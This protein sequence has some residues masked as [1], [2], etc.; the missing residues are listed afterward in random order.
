MV[1]SIVDISIDKIKADI[2]KKMEKKGWSLDEEDDD[3]YICFIKSGKD[4]D[5][6][7]LNINYPIVPD[8]VE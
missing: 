5:E 8:V 1:F 3:G 4:S 7:E 2:I 6:D